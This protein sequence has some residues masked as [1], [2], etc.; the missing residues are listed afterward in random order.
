[1]TDGLKPA[2]EL[3]GKAVAELSPQEKRLRLAELMKKKAGVPRT[4][5]LSFAQQRLWFL[6]QLSPGNAFYNVDTALP[7]DF[8]VDVKTLEKCL[9]EIVRRHEGLRTTFRAVGG[10]P[11]QVVAPSLRVTVPLVDLQPLPEPERLAEAHKL[12]NREAQQ[13]FDLSAGPLI[14]ATLLRLAASRHILLLTIHHIVADGW[15][16]EVFF[17]ELNTLYSAFC[18]GEPSP[19]PPLPIQYSDYALWQR[20]WLQGDELQSRLDYW[21]RQLADLPALELPCDHPRPAIQTYCGAFQPI[22]L[23]TRL[24]GDLKALSQAEGATLFMT[25]LAAFQVLLS[26][27]SGQDDIAVGTPIAGRNR[28]ELESLV[29]FFVNTLV[30]RTDLSG[31]PSFRQLLH[32]VRETALAAYAHPDLPFEMLV[33]ELQPQRDLSRN[34]LF[35]VMFQFL[36]LPSEADATDW[37]EPAFEVVRGTSIFDIALHV[38]EG[39]HGLAGN[40]EYSTELFD[41]AT[42]V[43]MS[44]H[45]ERLLE[46]AVAN[47]DRP[48]SRLRLLDDAERRRVLVDWNRTEAGYPAAKCVHH[49]FEEQAARTPGAVALVNG[50]SE[51]SYCELDRRANL[52]AAHLRALGVGPDVPAAIFM[53]RSLEMIVAVLGILKA[54]GAYVPLD[55]AYPKE[56]RAMILAD[57]RTPVVLAQE[58]FRQALAGQAAR[59]VCLDSEWDQIERE[60]ES[61]DSTASSGPGAANLAYVLYTSGSTGV[62]KGVAMTHGALVNLLVWQSTNS[63]AGAATRTLQYASLNFDVSFQEMFSTWSTGGALVLVTDQ[64]RR[65]AFLLLRF[66]AE[67][68]IERLFLPFVA[69][70]QLAEAACS[71]DHSKLSMREIV[72]AGEQLRITPQIASWIGKLEDCTLYNQY[73]PTESHV[74]TAFQLTGPPS[75]WP[76]LPPIGGPIANVAIYLLDRHLEPV[77]IGVPGELHIGGVALARGYWNNP[78][79]TLARFVP[80]PF[81]TPDSGARLY[82]TGDLARYRSDGSIEFLGRLDHQV[83]IRGYRVELG[84]V[85]SILSRHPA[86]REAVVT[87]QE[88]DPG[89]KRLVAYVVPASAS[90]PDAGHLRGFVLEHLPEYM[91]PAAFVFLDALPLLPNGKVNRRVLPAP[92]SSGLGSNRPEVPPRNATEETLARIWCSVLGLARVGVLDNF[93]ADLGGHSLLATQLTSRVRDAFGVHPPLTTI[94]EKPTIAALAEWIRNNSP[95][96]EDDDA[97]ILPQARQLRRVKIVSTP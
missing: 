44:A 48:V 92:D 75:G 34:P 26:R 57:V 58:S 8:A 36:K 60:N 10:E 35:Q 86:V 53:E 17:K 43:R 25:M 91:T 41:R 78:D 87:A 21:K 1:M 85:E 18:D 94:F 22:A 52:L 89:R 93:F 73:G 19:L 88:L 81:D 51:W 68:N 4:V 6:D 69:L 49:L 20:Q 16:L 30:M 84:E 14:R 54:G 9:N 76:S 32:Q 38:G 15:S 13:P 12:A 95:R 3:A 7:L 96:G 66:L 40:W 97:S 45:L 56:R 28:V 74:V 27:Y 31:D 2:A 47:P 46:E 64:T 62:P 24:T 33:N 5:P 39:P 77:P 65:D 29:G 90:A 63:K 70:N 55:P 11:V 72:T 79:Q 61:V 59:V 71:A 23:S 83:K 50:N 37:T 42:I 82:K 80:S 67:H